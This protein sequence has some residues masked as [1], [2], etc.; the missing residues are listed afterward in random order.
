ML[1]EIDEQTYKQEIFCRGRNGA[2]FE[3]PVRARRSIELITIYLLES[4]YVGGRCVQDGKMPGNIR[5]V[6]GIHAQVVEVA[7]TAA[8]KNRR[9]RVVVGPA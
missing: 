2:R 8:I 3:T 1:P 4:Q 6:T 7:G 9:I 5:Q